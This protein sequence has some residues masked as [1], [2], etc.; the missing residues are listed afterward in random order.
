M[1]SRKAP[2]AGVLPA[3]GHLSRLPR[4]LEQ[5]G[6]A[7]GEESPGHHLLLRYQPESCQIS[8]SVITVMHRSAHTLCPAGS[9]AGAVIAMPL[10]GI[11]VQYTGWSSVF[12]VYG[13][14]LPLHGLYLNNSNRRKRINTISC[15]WDSGAINC[16][17]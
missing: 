15:K 14:S 13:E 11:L 5:V 16:A 3:G 4:D 2:A 12:Y 9:Y 7:A 6:P 10:A 1:R 8:I 17:H